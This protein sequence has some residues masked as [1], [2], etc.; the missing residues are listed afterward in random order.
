MGGDTFSNDQSDVNS[1]P[2]VLDSR[3]YNGYKND[4]WYTTGTNWLVYPDIRLRGKTG[5]KIPIVKSNL[6]WTQVSYGSLPPP[7]VKFDD[8][9]ICEPY[10][11]TVIQ[12]LIMD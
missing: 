2:G 8:W 11:N 4:V 3:W 1:M 9:I 7:G 5:Q 6:L 12:T 10:F